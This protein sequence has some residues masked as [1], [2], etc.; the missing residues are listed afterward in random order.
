M[1]F[2][3]IDVIPEEILQYTGRD[4]SISYPQQGMCSLLGIL[5]SP[6]KK[7]VL[8]ITKGAYRGKELYS[9][10]LAMK[11]LYNTCIPVPEVYMFLQKDK[12]YYLL[13][14][15]STGVP[16]NTLFDESKDKLE[17]MAMIEEMALNLYKIHHKRIDGHT[18]E[19]F[20]KSQLYFAE[21]HMKNNTIDPSEF[22]F[23][24]KEITP[25]ELL[26]WLKDN[27]PEPAEACLIHGDFRPKNFLWNNN[28]IS[29]ILD[30][31]FCDIGDPYYDFAIFMYY[32]RDEVEKR[33]FFN[34]Y[35]FDRLDEARLKYYER[36]A[37]FINI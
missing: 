34:C 25:E 17:R 35:G 31:A 4:I 18:W 3:D 36:M 8:K 14:E 23:D 30:W 2:I 15:C 20:I 10:Y 1:K 32:L 6:R 22:V 28:R 26:R 37:P 12:L 19:N 24:G 7:Y 21:Q 27:K 16:L 29:A 33:H 13:R 5:E 9:E 11:N